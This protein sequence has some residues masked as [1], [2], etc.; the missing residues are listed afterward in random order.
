MLSLAPASACVPD[1]TTSDTRAAGP[2]LA[3]FISAI[4]RDDDGVGRIVVESHADKLVRRTLV[5]ITPQT[6]ILSA[7][8][9]NGESLSFDA[10]R[11]QDRV[12]VWCA[13]DVVQES[14]AD[15]KATARKI[16]LTRRR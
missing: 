3:G 16:V 9:P 14:S 1:R 12:G 5:T 11:L 8:N 10:L 4:E 2:C 7:E 6:T 15:W 13:G